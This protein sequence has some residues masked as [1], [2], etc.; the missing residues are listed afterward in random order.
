MSFWADVASLHW[1]IPE[2]A[3]L[4]C[5]HLGWFRRFFCRLQWDGFGLADRAAAAFLDLLLAVAATPTR[6]EDEGK[7]LSGLRSLSGYAARDFWSRRGE[8]IPRAAYYA[9]FRSIITDREANL[10]ASNA[11]LHRTVEYAGGTLPYND[12]QVRLVDQR[13]GGPIAGREILSPVA[14]GNHWQWAMEPGQ[15]PESILPGRMLEGLP[16]SAVVRS[17][18]ALLHEIGLLVNPPAVAPPD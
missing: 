13:V 15:V 10:P 14:E 8:E 11:L 5:G 17:H 18:L 6:P 2:L 4:R 16:R 9:A 3:E 1:P 7:T 12:M